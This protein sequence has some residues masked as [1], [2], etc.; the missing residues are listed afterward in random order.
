MDFLVL[1]A[2]L[3]Q[4]ALGREA[5]AAIGRGVE[6][7]MRHGPGA[8]EGPEFQPLVTGALT[9]AAQASTLK[10]ESGGLDRPRQRQNVNPRRL[11]PF[12]NAR[13]SLG[14]RPR[15]NH[16]VLVDDVIT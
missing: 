9:L 3:G 12:E 4:K 5:K 6:K 15:G 16:I 2:L 11:G 8:P 13:A 10:H 7:D 1:E 14:R